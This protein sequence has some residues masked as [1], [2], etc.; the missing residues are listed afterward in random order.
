MRLSSNST[1]QSVFYGVCVST[2]MYDVYD[3]MPIAVNFD[4]RG[5]FDASADHVTPQRTCR[6]RVSK[7]P[8]VSAKL[9]KLISRRG[10]GRRGSLVITRPSPLGRNSAWAAEM[11]A[12]QTFN[13]PRQRKRAEQSGEKRE[14][15]SGLPASESLYA[16]SWGSA[17]KR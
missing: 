17:S 5:L 12:N 10:R 1:Q 11:R 6:C 3:F 7:N 15:V 8:A 4:A 16:V 14:Q 13:C 2:W 9:R